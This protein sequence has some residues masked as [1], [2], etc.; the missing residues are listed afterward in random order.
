M[1]EIDWNIVERLTRA[2]PGSF[3]NEQG[4]FVAHRHANEYFILRNCETELDVKCKVLE[5]FSR[6]AY[7]S[8]PYRSKQKND[9][10]HAFML[11]GINRF[12]GTC[13]LKSDMEY[14]YTYLG[15]AIRHD[16]TVEFITQA[17]YNMG[18][19]DQFERKDEE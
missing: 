17:N 5:W 4:E 9:E 2:F 19:F 13:F 3:I 10:F 16:K 6:G 12:L 8:E 11:N 15:N 14:V 1:N 18:F 7:K